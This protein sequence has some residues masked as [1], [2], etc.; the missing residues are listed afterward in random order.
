LTQ[1]DVEKIIIGVIGQ[2][3]HYQLPDAKGFTS[4]LRHLNG[5]TDVLRQRL[6]DEV[7]ATTFADLRAFAD[8]LD[9][10]THHG[11]VVVLGSEQAIAAANETLA[12]KLGVLK[13]L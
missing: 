12:E 8:Q 9:Q 3:D 1:T 13:V 7:L 5:D 6:R 2:M 10:V 4:L 11:T